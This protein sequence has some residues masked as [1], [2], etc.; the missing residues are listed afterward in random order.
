MSRQISLP[1][2]P[3]SVPTAELAKACR[4]IF[5]SRTAIVEEA[6]LEKADEG[7]RRAK[8]IE[9]YVA[10]KEHKDEARRAARVLETAVGEA[11]GEPKPGERND[12]QLIPRKVKVAPQDAT[13]FRRMAQHRQLWW[14]VLEEKA[15]SRKQVLRIIDAALEPAPGGPGK[16]I[17]HLGTAQEWLQDASAAD[18]LL[19]DPPYSTDVEDI[20]R[21]ASEW[22]P[23]ALS[24]LKTTG[25][26]F[27]FIGAYMDEF[28]AYASQPLPDGWQ[29]GVPHAWVY[30]NA[31]GPT[32]EKD[33]IRNWQCIVTAY[34]PD[35]APLRS[36]RITELLAGFIENAPD[37]RQEIKWH[38][39]QKPM[40]LVERL[41]RLGTAPGD[42]VIDPF[43]G[44]GTTLLAAQ[45]LGRIGFGCESD[46][47]SFD[48]CTQRGCEWTQ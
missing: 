12:L 1:E 7:L 5:D 47:A 11:L 15:L 29:W 36:D 14:P 31:I 21:F 16:A 8:A 33:F 6:T 25:R 35:A 17:I 46:R 45:E 4:S 30:R 44:S 18:L 34:G 13:R 40:P 19:T 22:L 10:T 32:P 37:G 24:R 27:I 42:I 41:I 20:V 43:A 38:S 39:W 3:S 26:A 48:I 23:L 2:L 9:Q 28:A